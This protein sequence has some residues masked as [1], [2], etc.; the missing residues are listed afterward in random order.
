[1]KNRKQLLADFYLDLLAIP[2][3]WRE[4]KQRLYAE[5]EFILAEELECTVEMV[6]HIFKRMSEEDGK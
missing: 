4:G 6:Q 3:E 1:M 2:E 5:L